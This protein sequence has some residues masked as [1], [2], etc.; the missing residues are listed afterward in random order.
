MKRW[1]F[2]L[3]LLMAID[4][5]Q[6]YASE[7]GLTSEGIV[8]YRQESYE[9]A[10]QLLLKADV[11]ES[12]GLNSYYLGLVQKQVGDLE[13]A[14]ASFR[15]ALSAGVPE[16]NAAPELA[17]MLL[18]SGELN[19][20]EK[21]LV[22][23]ERGRIGPAETAYLRGELL[24]K[25]GDTVGAVAAFTAA[26]ESNPAISQQADIQIAQ[27]YLNV[28]D[29]RSALE[30][31][32][33]V[34]TANP[35]N[36]LAD[37]AREYERRISNLAD[38]SRNWRLFL[39]VNYQ[40]DDNA[41]VKPSTTIPGLDLPQKEDS[42][43]SQTVRLI[44]DMPDGGE[45]FLQSQYTLHNN[46]YFNLSEYSQLSQTLSVTPGYRLA[47]GA[48]SLPVAYNHTLLD[49]GSYSRQLSARPAFAA[50]LSPGHIGQASIGYARREF[51]NNPAD[52][53]ENR[54]ADSYAAL[55]GYLYLYAEGKG[56]FNIRYELS[57][58]DARGRNWR[59][60]GNRVL[61]DLLLPLGGDTSL[62]L[63]LEG[64]W[65]EFERN[66]NYGAERRDSSLLLSLAMSRRLYR[67]LYM[68]LQYFHMRTNS[69]IPLYDFDR[70]V[71]SAG[72]ELRF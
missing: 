24:L 61:G 30:S 62:I 71:A 46:T 49:Y 6:G 25:K 26:K 63:S 65:Q 13:A 9:E 37:F 52:P 45:S 3:V 51:Y 60:T 58:E 32:Q 42:S 29:H 68:N 72:V 48:I 57:R 10:L 43:S 4:S 34:I 35:D 27:A 21:L 41:V 40:Y 19:E 39:G 53:K 23:A 55:L 1:L 38:G 67:N 64:L 22:Q 54:S 7:S 5:P 2:L 18:A 16:M 14:A 33:T 15:A 59:N 20:A 28:N 12:S 44:Y 56:F 69:N 66:S 31:L 8:L 11:L 36:E 17:A 70:D 47:A 50:V